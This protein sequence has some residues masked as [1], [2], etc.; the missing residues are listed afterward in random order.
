LITRPLWDAINH[1]YKFL[2][3]NYRYA[4]TSPFGKGGLRGIYLKKSPLTPLFQRGGLNSYNYS[5]FSAKVVCTKDIPNTTLFIH[6][7]ISKIA[8]YLMPFVF[9]VGNPVD[10]CIIKNH[11]IP[12]MSAF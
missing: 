10:K 11:R 8:L 5:R 9:F 7:K 6:K 12:H 3:F 4:F 1:S 2:A